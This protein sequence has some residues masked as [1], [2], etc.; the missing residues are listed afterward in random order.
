MTK[1]SLTIK[2]DD[3]TSVRK[4]RRDLCGFARVFMG[5]FWGEWVKGILSVITQSRQKALNGQ[6]YTRDG[7]SI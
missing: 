2:T 6:I 5:R 7:L 4:T 3:V 1:L